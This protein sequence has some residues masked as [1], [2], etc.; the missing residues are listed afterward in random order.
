MRSGKEKY[1]VAIS[2][3]NQLSRSLPASQEGPQSALQ[4]TNEGM[5]QRMTLPVAVQVLGQE[6]LMRDLSAALNHEGEEGLPSLEV[7]ASLQ[8]SLS[9]S[10]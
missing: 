7:Q 10:A 4:I 1:V 8:S 5:S 3:Q 2:W 9:L 6:I